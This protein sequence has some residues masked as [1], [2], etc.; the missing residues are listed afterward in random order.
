M[1]AAVPADPNATTVRFTEQMKGFVKLDASDPRDA[2]EDAR[3]LDEKF[4]FELT[5]ET[6]DIDGFVSD[7]AH[8]G[9][10]SG[11]VDADIF[12]GPVPVQRGWFNL[13]VQ[14]ENDAERRMI[15]RLWL[16][17]DSGAPFTVLGFKD[18][19]DDPGFDLWDD[20]TTLYVQLLTGH[21][22]PPE[23]GELG[24]LHPVGDRRRRRCGCAAD[25]AAGFREADDD[26]PHDRPGRA[27]GGVRIRAPVPRTAVGHLR[28]A[29][30][31]GGVTA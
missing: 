23:T 31:S 17:L 19:H 20:T 21:V 5:I 18:V 30:P 1:D 8:A 2:Y 27:G 4:M 3:I 22:P 28:G 12:G 25:Q 9:S 11:F 29:G 7:P 14:P 10:A 13:F 6:S 16:T 26:I 24:E 15:Y